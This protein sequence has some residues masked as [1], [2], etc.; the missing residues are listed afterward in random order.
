MKKRASSIDVARLAGVSQSTVSLVL[1]GR[2]DARISDETR[3]RVFEAARQLGYTRNALAHALKTG[4]TNRIAI[5]AN[6][7]Y[8]FQ[9]RDAY[10]RDVLAG[11]A[12][13]ALAGSVNLLLISA[14]YPLW[15]SL[16]AELLGGSADG[17]LLIGHY[18]ED[19]LTLALLEAQ[20]PTVC[21]SYHVNHPRCY[22]VDCDNV[23]G[24]Y[25]A[26][27]HLLE[28]GHRH[29]GIFHADESSSWIEE[30]WEG[31]CRAVAEAGLP[32]ETLC[33][34]GFGVKGE[35]E[36]ARWTGRVADWFRSCSP[37]LSALALFGE[38]EAQA[39]VE[40][41]PSFGLRV[42]DDVSIVTFNS[43][44]VSERARPPLT[45]IWQPLSTIG[46]TALEMILQLVRGETPAEPMRRFP[47]RLDIRASCRSQKASDG[48]H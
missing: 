46:E 27:K 3:A 38:W 7:P 25:L 10:Y 14:R 34:A 24:G 4:R 15:Q 42:P 1:N 28:L 39:L 17:V 48:E 9:D 29:I 20:F 30:R 43:T 41:L 47:V 19:A 2:M 23:A 32:E 35:E 21:I 33:R 13:G 11:I 8:C 36:D 31:A 12:R 40:E 6:S 44:S 45:A 37:A 26:V 16:Y 18:Q 22:S 5:V